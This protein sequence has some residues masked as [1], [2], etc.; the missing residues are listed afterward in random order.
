[1]RKHDDLFTWK[2]G[3]RFFR[4]LRAER[5]TFEIGAHSVD[6]V[7]VRDVADLLDEPDFAKQFLEQD[8]APYMGVVLVGYCL[9]ALA[10]PNLTLRPAWQRPAAPVVGLLTGLVNG[11]TGSHARSCKLFFLPASASVCDQLHFVQCHR[12]SRILIQFGSGFNS[13]LGNIIGV[14]L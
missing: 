8:R 10:N 11:L 5:N 6:L 4:G 7:Q 3:Q 12:Q 13:S 2:D 14:I 9:F 1:M